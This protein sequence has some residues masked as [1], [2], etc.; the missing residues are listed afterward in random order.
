M[1]MK[2]GEKGTRWLLHLTLWQWM[3]CRALLS[4][5]M[6]KVEEGVQEWE[7]ICALLW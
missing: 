2:G 3:R 7:D 4:L 5:T 6:L 1:G